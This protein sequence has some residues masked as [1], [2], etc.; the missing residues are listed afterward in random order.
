SDSTSGYCEWLERTVLEV[1]YGSNPSRLPDPSP[2]GRQRRHSE[3]LR[4]I[5]LLAGTSPHDGQ[6]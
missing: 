5:D 1:T 3:R 2:R 4:G 6:G